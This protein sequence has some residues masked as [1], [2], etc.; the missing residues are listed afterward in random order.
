M[1]GWRSVKKSD[2]SD[3]HIEVQK[4]IR[5]RRVINMAHRCFDQTSKA[6][7]GLNISAV[8]KHGAAK[9]NKVTPLRPRHPF[10]TF[11]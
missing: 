8:L 5:R 4:L 11:L 10:K 1:V 3:G 6:R 2:E 9:K 7:G